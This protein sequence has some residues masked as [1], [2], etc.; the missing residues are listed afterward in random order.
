VICDSQAGIDV[1]A[2]GG[3][4]VC[5]V[6]DVHRRVAAGSAGGQCHHR[7]ADGEAGDAV[8][9]R[10]HSAGHFEAGDVRRSRQP[11]ALLV[12]PLPEVDVD[13]SD[14]G[15]GDVDGDLTRAR[16]RIRQLGDGEHGWIAIVADLHS[17]HGTAL[18][19]G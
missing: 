1:I 18:L 19:V 15:V 7:L 10:P 14:C 12:Q 5:L 3:H 2:L 8:A 9:Q 6:P 11:L 16:C 4:H 17:L 13:D